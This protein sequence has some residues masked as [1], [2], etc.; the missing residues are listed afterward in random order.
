MARKPSTSHNKVTDGIGEGRPGPGRP[1]GSVN[2]VTGDVRAMV[3]QALADAGGSEYLLKQA[4]E[5]PAAFMT[6]VGKVLPKE[7]T[8]PGGT[9]LFDG[10]RFIGVEVK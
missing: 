9:P 5:N 3:L 2:K 7:V 10:V 8:G 6:L 4:G 1:K